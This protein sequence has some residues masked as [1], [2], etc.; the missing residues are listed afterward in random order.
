MAE[1]ESDALVPYM[2]KHVLEDLAH[3]A[4]NQKD[5]SVVAA[6]ISDF[7]PS[8]GFYDA[9]RIIARKS[10]VAFDDV[11]RIFWTISN[12]GRLSDSL[13]IA[14]ETLPNLITELLEKSAPKDWRQEN[15]DAWKATAPVVAGFLRQ[16]TPAHPLVVG[17]KAEQLA[18]LH[19]NTLAS[20]RLISDL[21][22]VFDDTGKNILESLIIH[23]LFIEYSDGG[24]STKRIALALDMDDVAR[25]RRLCERA[26]TKAATLKA[27]V[28]SANWP[29]AVIGEASTA[30]APNP[31]DEE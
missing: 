26:E 31:G 3:L 7:P 4:K 16:L 5:L 20:S 22:P 14:P 1:R 24:E 9:A 12:L 6:R 23:T 15:I 30:I 28:A 10:G 18:Y 13:S 11:H 17:R 29:T 25:L 19:Q 21:R 2:T 27:A 8:V